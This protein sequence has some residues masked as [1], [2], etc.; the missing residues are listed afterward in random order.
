ME[1][2]KKF[3]R[4]MRE[5]ARIETEKMSQ[6]LQVYFI[7]GS[8]NCHKGPLQVMKEALDGGITLFQF[9]EK[10]EGALT[11]EKKSPICQ[12]VTSAM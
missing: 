12:T 11:G 3:V 7:M 2:Q 10:G 9:R 5:M 1:K 4:E 6:L 8:N